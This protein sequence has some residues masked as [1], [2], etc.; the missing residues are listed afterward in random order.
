MTPRKTTSAE[1]APPPAAPNREPWADAV[2]QVPYRV[3]VEERAERNFVVRLR[4][5]QNGQWKPQNLKEHG[6][7]VRFVDPVTGHWLTG[8]KLEARQEWARQQAMVKYLELSGVASGAPGT[9]SGRPDPA[10]PKPLLTIVGARALI[11]DPDKGKYR[12]ETQHRKEVLRAL[13][14]AERVWGADTPWSAIGPDEIRQLG[15]RRVR[16]LVEEAAR[17]AVAEAAR[18]DAAPGAEPAPGDSAR[19]LRRARGRRGK[20][21]RPSGGRVGRGYAGAESFVKAI[22]AVAG[23]LRDRGHIPGSAAVAPARWKIEL[24][25]F[26]RAL[27]KER[28]EDARPYVPERPRHTVEELRRILTAAPEVDARLALL[29]ALG[30]ELRAGQVVR[31][32]R[33]DV[34]LEPTEAAPYGQLTVHGAGKKRGEVV[35]LT[36]GQRAAL[37]VAIGAADPERGYLRDLEAAFRAGEIKDYPL[38][39]AGQMPGVRK[40]APVATV[41]RHAG[42]PPMSRDQMRLLFQAAEAKAGVAHQAG[43]SF[44]G[45]RRA[46][47][48]G[49][50]GEDI[51]KHGLMHF[52]GWADTQVPDQIYAD[53]ESETHR[54]EARD[55]RAKVRGEAE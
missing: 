51:S 4:W 14:F 24:K 40:G 36:R 22:V 46:G 9:A 27:Q 12:T 5:R 38:F 19:D 31:A 18:A 35:F 33:T 2:G 28:G 52:G 25:E 39:P 54:A 6:R 8:K 1:T 53:Q 50:T 42:A 41:D 30:A 37:D 26:W 15:A 34:V 10:A 17:L 45:P 13:A 48:D 32:V 44:Y 16:E 49:A 11:T 23:W 21:L 20:A 47:V 43:R 3:I 29:L 7:S 55:V